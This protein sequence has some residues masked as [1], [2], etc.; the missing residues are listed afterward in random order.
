MQKI[1]KTIKEAAG[2]LLVIDKVEGI[3][4]DELVEIETQD[5]KI[6]RGKVFHSQR[7][8]FQG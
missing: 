1:Y 8:K 4:Y 7:F 5:G 6:K 3:K 2:P